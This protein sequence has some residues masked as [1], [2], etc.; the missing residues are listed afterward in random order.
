ML[1]IIIGGFFIIWGVVA[2]LPEM[3]V[4]TA[5]HVHNVAIA[6]DGTLW[7]WGYNGRGQLGD[8]TIT[9]RN[10]PV[11]I[12][13][14]TDWV[15]VAAGGS[16]N[17]AIRAD[18]TLWGWGANGSGQLGDGTITDRRR[19]VQIG[20]D[21]DWIN[22]FV[23]GGVAFATKSD[24]S[25]WV[26]GSNYRGFLHYIIYGEYNY[27]TIS[28]DRNVHIFTPTQ[29]GEDTDWVSVSISTHH[30]MAIKTDGTLW[31]WG[32][33]SSRSGTPEQKGTDTDWISVS[34][35]PLVS[36][37]IK[38]DGTLWAWGREHWTPQTPRQVGTDANWLKVV[39]RIAIRTD[40]TLWA[41]RGPYPFTGYYQIGAYTD[42]TSISVGFSHTVATRADGSLYSFG[43]SHTGT[44]GNGVG[45]FSERESIRPITRRLLW[46]EVYV[47]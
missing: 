35:S 13:T 22:V 5:G 11:Q 19:P 25:L 18:G 26:W 17:L 7:T 30:V 15:L 38:E 3:R 42:W 6:T 2:A 16:S 9:Q 37:A 4:V 10:R 46:H 23:G 20:T 47:P 28:W 40:G 1:S 33:Q 32:V 29:F 21:T 14:D 45:S 43:R 27:P 24:G 34:T 44:L 36:M 8:G 31:E 39:G 41:W 12:C